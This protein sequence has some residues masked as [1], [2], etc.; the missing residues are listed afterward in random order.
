MARISTHEPVSQ[1]KRVPIVECGEPLVDFLKLSSR[2]VLGKSRWQYTRAHLL[3]ETVA[4]K[5]ARAAESLPAGYMLAVI[6]GWRPPHIQRRMYAAAWARWRE[7]H[8][9]WSDLALRRLVNRFTAPPNAK[10]PPPH[11][12]GGALDVMLAGP[13]GV[14]LDHMSPFPPRDRHGYPSDTKRLSSE[15]RRNRDILAAALVSSGITN[16]PSEYWHWSYGD[17]GWAYRGGHPHAIYGPV[18]PQGYV[19]PEADD[20]DEPL[21]WVAPE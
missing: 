19:P 7:A 21:R 13:D 5:L 12:T 15:A 18:K 4:N 8:P 10:V 14:E 20:T 1:L 16:Y 9:D 2:I 17:Q 6:E 3:R 11:S